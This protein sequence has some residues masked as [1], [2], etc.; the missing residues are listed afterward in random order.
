MQAEFWLERWEQN[1]IGFHQD[2]INDHLQAFWEQLPV[3]AGSRIFVPLCGKSR[4]MLWLRSQGFEIMG[5]EI[6]PIA[7][8]DFFRENQLEPRIAPQGKFERW[9]ADGL[10]ILL[11]D[12]FDLNA[13]DVAGCAGVFDRASL[14]ALP[15]SMRARYA[16]HFTAILPPAVQ[17]LL[18]TM[19]YP[20]TEMNGPPFAVEEVEVRKFYAQNYTVERLF[21]ADILA[22]NPGFRQ[23]GVTRLEEKVYRLTP[24]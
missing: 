10:A 6:S 17:T 16:E 2:A 22:E 13:E 24:R 12:F 21:A 5:I 9:E 1:Q 7:V 15:P 23:R 18:V 11:G 8:R 19:E 14:I 20:Q 4:D 3:P